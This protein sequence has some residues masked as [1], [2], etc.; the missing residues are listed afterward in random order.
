M[1]G[2]GQRRP[3][4]LDALFLRRALDALLDVA[5]RFEV[6][7]Q[8]E[9]VAPA[10]LR[11]EALRVLP[12]FVEDAAVERAARAVAHQAVE[13]P[14]GIELL[15]RGLGRRDPRQARAVNHR[16]AVFEA[17][18]V[19][20][21]AQHET[22]DRRPAPDL[23][24]DDLVHRRADANLLRIEADRRPRQDVHAPEMRARRR[25]RGLVVEPLNE[26]HVLAMRHHR[27]QPGADFHV[28][29]G[30]LG[31]P[32]DRLDAV[33]EEDNPQPQRRRVR[34]HRSGGLT[35]ERQRFHPGQRQ[36]DSYASQEVTP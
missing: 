25:G 3:P 18:L 33:R 14:R 6:F 2:C 12:H 34:L 13:R 24:G 31:P 35:E 7:A 30:A 28:G 9:V 5:D 10:D 8:L 11:P 1:S 20:L 17:Q 22:R 21:D 36:R 27:Q 16:Q 19:R 32:V 15:G 26:Q 4:A 29:P 23:R